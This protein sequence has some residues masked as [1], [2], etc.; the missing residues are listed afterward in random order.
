MGCSV[1]GDTLQYRHEESVYH[2][3]TRQV[4]QLFTYLLTHKLFSSCIRRYL[5]SRDCDW[6]MPAL[7]GVLLTFSLQFSLLFFNMSLSRPQQSHIYGSGPHQHCSVLLN[8]IGQ[9]TLPK[10]RLSPFLVRSLHPKGKTEVILTAKIETTHFVGDHLALSFGICNHWG[11]M[12]AWK[13]VSNFLRFFCKSELSQAVAYCKDLS[14]NLPGQLPHLAH[15][16]PDFIQI[17]SFSS[18]PNEPNRTREDRF[19]L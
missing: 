19:A 7:S 9:R 18:E 3:R 5:V 8:N 16:V 15:N 17:S 10:I 1:S 6:V 14:Q 2:R 12:T 13:I 4:T 11:V